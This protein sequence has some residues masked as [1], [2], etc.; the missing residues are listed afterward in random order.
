MLADGG[1][2]GPRRRLVRLLARHRVRAAP[3][4]GPSVS[5]PADAPESALICAEDGPHIHPRRR[6][7][8]VGQGN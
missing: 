7:S 1:A 4:Q 8:T 3:A 6:A 5:L 2:D